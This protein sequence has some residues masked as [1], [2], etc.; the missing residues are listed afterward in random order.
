MRLVERAEEIRKKEGFGELITRAFRY[1]LN[2]YRMWRRPY[3]VWNRTDS[4]SRWKSIQNNIDSEDGSAIDIG[5][6]SG[7]FTKKL[8]EKGLF[9]IGVEFDE[10]RLKESRA[11]YSE[12]EG[13]SFSR[14][15]VGPENIEN[16]PSTDICLLLTVYHHWTAHYGPENAENMLRIVSVN[17]DKI[18]FELPKDLEKNNMFETSIDLDSDQGFRDK[19]IEFVEKVLPGSQVK[20]IHK[21]EYPFVED[22]EDFMFLIDCSNI[23]SMDQ[24]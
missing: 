14:Y 8:S 7:F 10:K 5:C 17:S 15:R 3:H 1:G 13:L 6:A 11:L 2:K 19:H 22:R 23:T 4:K 20:L 16:L 18:F 9:S 24:F 21:A 12:E